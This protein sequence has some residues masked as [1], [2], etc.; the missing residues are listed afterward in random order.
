MK[1]LK[2]QIESLHK[3]FVRN[4]ES[5][6]RP[7]I[8]EHIRVKYLGRTGEIASLMSVLQTLSSEEKRIFG[9]MLNELKKNCE[10]AFNQKKEN[11]EK[12]KF[13]ILEAKEKN[14][15][16]TKYKPDRLT[17]SLHPYTKIIEH[18]QNTFISMGYEIVDGPELEEDYYNF[19]A[20]NIPEDHPARDMQDTF[21]LTLPG[22]LLR[23]HTSSVQIRTM[24]NRQPPISIISSGRVYRNEATDAS[25]DFVFMQ[26]EALFVDKDISIANLLATIKQF[27]QA[28]FERKDLEIRVRPGYFPFV[29]PGLE[30]DVRCPFCIIGCSVCK[31]TRWIEMGGSGLVNPN[32]LKYCGIDS[33]KYSGFAFGL[34][35]SR[36]VM[37]KYDINDV[38]LLSSGRLE[39]LEQ[40]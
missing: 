38:R 28:I 22:K 20:L 13:F 7:D 9:P 15:D 33:K 10:Q 23:T 27:F 12:E 18:I 6:T 36:F 4:L 26:F 14:F 5:A 35:L 21:W 30:V 8:I 16:V 39:F 32:V 11:L 3:E 37:L 40:F 1:D 34:G 31:K 29:E 19:Q 2:H 24:E 17:G 25:H